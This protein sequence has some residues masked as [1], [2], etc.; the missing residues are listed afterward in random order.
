MS[1]SVLLKVAPMISTFPTPGRW[2]SVMRKA[3]AI[4]GCDAALTLSYDFSF[5]TGWIG[6]GVQ[7]LSFFFISKLMGLSPKFGY[8]GHPARYFDFIVVNLAFVRF[9]ATAVQCFQSAIRND[10]L[11]GTLEAIMATPTSLPV[12]IL[13]RGLWAFT[14]TFAQA[15]LFMVLAV[16]LGLSLTHVN[17]LSVIVFTLLT[18]ACMSPLGVMSA[19]SIMTFKQAG[20]TGFVMGGL[21][22]LL[23]GV[24]FPVSTLPLMLQYVS[25]ALPITHA[26][27][28]IRGAVHG[29]TLAQLAPEAIWLSIAGA[30]LLPLSLWSFARAV[31]RAKMDGTLGHY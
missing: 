21:T 1:S 17:I 19:A 7:V 18:I 14:L 8:G 9:Q 3:G 4:F 27:D 15:T 24:L 22:Q 16:M 31:Q 6:I 11:A 12:I 25:W 28:G 30:I 29:A 20:G 23:G 2:R 5:W 13:S 10:Q 26:L